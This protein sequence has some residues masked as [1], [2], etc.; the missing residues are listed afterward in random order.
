MNQDEQF[1]LWAGLAVI[2]V[3]VIVGLIVSKIQRKK[4]EWFRAYVLETSERYHDILKLNEKFTFLE[5]SERYTYHRCVNSKAQL[6]RFNYDGFLEETIE[7]ER[8]TF[9]EIIRR[10]K[11]NR[12]MLKEY[13]EKLAHG[14]AK[15][16]EKD[17]ILD[18][19]VPFEKYRAY[20]EKITESLVK[21]PVI[22]PEVVCY[23]SYTSPKGRNSY[24]DGKLYN[25]NEVIVHLDNVKKRQ[26]QKESKEYQRRIMTDSLRY[27]IMKRDGFH[28]VLC[29]RG[30]EDGVK[31]HVDH[32]IPVSKGGKTVPENL[33]TLCENCNLGKRDKYDNNSVN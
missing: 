3:I 26:K 21:E 31:L 30:A 7:N 2:A 28:C 29:G 8:V 15:L 19:N 4:D 20:E 11:I 9:E 6:A 10:T 25:F 5:L 18:E 24:Q 17:E 16:R 14:I 27:D 33:R 32:I 13:T 23:A 22:N 12:E 1:I